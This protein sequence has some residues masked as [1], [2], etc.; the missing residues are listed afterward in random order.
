[1]TSPVVVAVDGPSGS[2]KSSVSRGIARR[3]GMAYLDT[4]AMYRA[5]TW[6][7]LT[8]GVDPH[9]PAAVSR[10]V[11]KMAILSGTD[12][13][14][15]TISVDGAD[16]GSPIRGSEVTGAVSLVSAVPEVRRT[17]VQLQ[18]D[19]VA[20]SRSAGLGIVVEG[21]DI[22]SVVLPDADVKV[23]LTADT[24]VRAHRRSLQD[25]DSEH[26]SEGVGATEE[27]LRRRDELDSSR[28]AS[29]LKPA[30]DAVHVDATHLD[31]EQTI[32]AV[33]RLVDSAR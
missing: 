12:P 15:P 13:A 33:A 14:N 26:G 4:G 3:F 27:S 5:A 28:K 7:V 1:M 24:S 32:D 31:L 25:A 21:R 23:F 11:V 8:L 17:M 18:R 29:P 10:A 19:V 6:R 20:A 16:A 30:E 9:D 2:G 22:G